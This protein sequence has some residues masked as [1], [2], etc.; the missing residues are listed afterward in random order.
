MTVDLSFSEGQAI[1]VIWGKDGTVLLSDH[2]EA[3]YFSQILPSTQDYYILVRGR[4]DGETVY[5][6]VI[7]IPPLMQN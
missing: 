2:A 7:T 3:S 4:P 5:R 1:L 6:M